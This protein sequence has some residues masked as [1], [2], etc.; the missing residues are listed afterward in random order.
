MENGADVDHP[1][2]SVA[3]PIMLILSIYFYVSVPVPNPRPL[4]LLPSITPTS[5]SST[6]SR[7]NTDHMTEPLQ[8]CDK[9]ALIS[10]VKN[11]C[12]RFQYILQDFVEEP[13]GNDGAL[14]RHEVI[15]IIQAALLKMR[16]AEKRQQDKDRVAF[17]VVVGAGVATTK[18]S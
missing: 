7:L 3:S 9:S 2:L 6:M 14:D 5:V 18:G 16:R 8:R 10:V 12:V 4:S 1:L 17:T 11:L 15:I 13:E